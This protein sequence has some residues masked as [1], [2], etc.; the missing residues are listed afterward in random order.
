[1]GAQLPRGWR[2]LA[3]ELAETLPEARWF[4][5]ERHGFLVLDVDR[6]RARAD[7][8]TVDIEDPHARPHPAAAWLNRRDEPGRLHE[9]TDVPAVPRAPAGSPA[10]T[11]PRV[12]VP[13]R[14]AELAGGARAAVRRRTARLV[15]AGVL[16][17]AAA[18]GLWRR[19]IARS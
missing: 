5:L 19:V 13:D 8:F 16:I 9:A 12:P 4:E 18:A 3:G 6:D 14:P 7:W 10:A 11:A 15:A 1:M 2:K 17:T